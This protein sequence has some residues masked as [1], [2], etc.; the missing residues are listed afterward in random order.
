MFTQLPQIEDPWKHFQELQKK[1]QGASDPMANLAFF[2]TVSEDGLPSVRTIVT[3]GADEEGF[4]LYFNTLSPKWLDLQ[5]NPE[6]ELLCYW[7][8]QNS[9]FRIRGSWMM[10]SPE[11]VQEGWNYQ[12]R[13]SKLLDLFYERNEQQSSPVTFEHF[14][15]EIDNLSS[16]YTG[17]VPFAESA[18][19]LLIMPDTIEWLFL[20]GESRCHVRLLFDKAADGTWNQQLLVP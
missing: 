9:Q 13:E 15:S 8:S 18:S 1:A 3:R 11:E 7:P 16:Q 5:S 12:P 6:F 19:G 20:Q 17:E 14:K 4:R 2:A 10:L